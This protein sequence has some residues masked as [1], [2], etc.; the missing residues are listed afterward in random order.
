MLSRDEMKLVTGGSGSGGGYGNW[1]CGCS[2]GDNQP[3]MTCSYW[4]CRGAC[5]GYGQWTGVCVSAG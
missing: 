3:A 1:Y 5:I 2:I 4:T